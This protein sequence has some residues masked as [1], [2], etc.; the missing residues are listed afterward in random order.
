VLCPAGNPSEIPDRKSRSEIL[1]ETK[2][3]LAVLLGHSFNSTVLIDQVVF[4]IV[5]DRFLK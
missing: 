1:S 2:M 5:V 4:E 3:R